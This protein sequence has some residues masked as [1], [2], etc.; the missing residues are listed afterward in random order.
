MK[1]EIV[2]DT[3]RVAGRQK[4]ISPIPIHLKIFSNSTPNITLVDL[5]GLTKVPVGDQPEDIESQIEELVLTYMQNENAIILA[6]TP[7]NQDIATSEAIKVARKVDPGGERTIAVVTKV[8]LMERGIQ[9]MNLLKGVTLPVK[10]GL[11]G[12]I[13]RS[14]QDIENGKSIKSALEQEEKYFVKNHPN[15]SSK[16]GTSYLSERLSIILMGHVKKCLP[17]L[18]ARVSHM[19]GAQEA[20]I[21]DLGRPITRPGPAILD[22][23]NTFCEEFRRIINGNSSH[24]QT[25]EISGGAK[26]FYIFQDTFGKA[27]E[28]FDPMS[29]LTLSDVRHAVRNSMGTRPSLFIPEI[30][31]EML[32]KRQIALLRDICLRVVDLSYDELA[33]TIMV[34]CTRHFERFDNLKSGSMTAGVNLLSERLAPTREMVENLLSIEQSYI[35][36]NHP[37]FIYRSDLSSLKLLYMIRTF[38]LL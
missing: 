28:D 20:T 6:I 13:N 11:V 8:D 22:L 5:P 36:T 26:L 30:A 14:Q 4:T 10:L 35:N 9:T 19:R 3:E 18:R 29:G 15:I 37:D 32:V 12:V 7:G 33:N 21:V 25:T 27:L 24:I 34:A 16:M 38:L 23:I 31:F 17:S 2:L 1:Q